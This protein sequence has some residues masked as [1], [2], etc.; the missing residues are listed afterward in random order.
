M[1]KEITFSTTKHTATVLL[2][3]EGFKK[4]TELGG[5]WSPVLKRGNYYF[6]KRFSTRPGGEIIE[7]HRYLLGSPKGKYVDHI[8]QNTLDNRLCNLRV[9]SNSTNLRNGR[10]R[11]N[12]KSGTK[13]VIWDKS[14]NKWMAFIRVDYKHIY[15]GRFQFKEDAIKARRDAESKYWSS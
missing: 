11:D 1:N 2:C 6:Q 7:L 15:L 12:N 3:D 5:K 8:N 4:I 14:R 10:L 9:V 13:G